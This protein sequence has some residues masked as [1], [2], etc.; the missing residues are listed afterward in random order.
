MVEVIPPK[1]PGRAQ[2]LIDDVFDTV[3]EQTVVI[4]GT[5]T[6]DAVIPSLARSLAAVQNQRRA[7]ETQIGQLLEAHPLPQS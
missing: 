1:A 5:G 6:L 2:R 7:L 3:D 4:P